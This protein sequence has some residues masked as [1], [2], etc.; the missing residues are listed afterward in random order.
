[1]EYSGDQHADPEGTK[2]RDSRQC[3]EHPR[4]RTGQGIVCHYDEHG[5]ETQRDDSRESMPADFA[6][7]LP[8]TPTIEDLA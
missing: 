6:A 8:E 4:T 3:L 1:M 7:V 5:Q 2:Y